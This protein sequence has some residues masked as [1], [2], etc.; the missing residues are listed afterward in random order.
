[1]GA[2]LPVDFDDDT[3][4]DQV[5]FGHMQM[6]LSG[7]Q[8]S[9]GLPICQDTLLDGDSDVDAQDLA[10]FLGCLSGAGVPAEPDCMSTP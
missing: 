9:Q 2:I 8:D 5:D 6:C 4:V 7:P 10:I 1:P 3:D